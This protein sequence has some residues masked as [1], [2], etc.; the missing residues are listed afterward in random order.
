MN[1]TS[2]FAA[3]D[4]RLLFAT[5]AVRLFAYGFL[6]VVLVLYLAAAGLSEARIGLLLS[7]TLAG[8]T[9]ISLYL[10]TRADRLGRRAMLLAGA[11]LMVF[12]GALF[13]VT[14]NFWLLLLAATVGVIS[15]AGNEVGPFLAIEQ[16]ALSEALPAERRTGAFAWYTL[17]GSF[18]TALGSLAGGALAS[19]LQ[20]AGAAPLNSYRAV[21]VGYGALG[22][23]LGVLFTRLSHGVEAP[24]ARR[25]APPGRPSFLQRSLGLSSSRGVVL[26]LSA[27]FSVD[28][29]AGGFV[30]QAFVAYWFH[31]RFG[32]D[33]A[34]LGA[35]FF[36]AN[37]LAG[38]SALSAA[39]VARRIGLVRT[40]VFTHLP[41]NVLL[42]LVPLMPTL[43]L[44]MAVLFLRFSISQMDVP[45]RQSFT[46]A[47]VDPGE[48][49]AAAGV[50]GIA[51]TVGSA[52]SP[53][54]AGPLYAAPALASLP[55]FIAGGLKI[56][57]DLALLVAFGRVAPPEERR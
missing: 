15:P 21:V 31:R 52:L 37:V 5:R 43:P 33:P 40:M 50:T 29:F 53:L 22:L 45:T 2:P 56:L 4:V 25:A 14:G 35:I 30:V 41:S 13:A 20:R 7:L 24:A 38:V 55:F 3:R 42:F 46:M 51:R 19:A 9:A 6:S 49:S 47:V 17:F 34:L 8:D 28:A 32:A 54:A 39:W 12:A 18:A 27:L 36:G 23:A 44:A 26:K 57:Y 16:A 48:R 11:G 1:G 10:T